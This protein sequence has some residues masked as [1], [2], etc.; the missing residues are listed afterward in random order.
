MYPIGLSSCGK[1]LCE[2][3]FAQYEAAGIA[4]MELSLGN[5][6]Y[7]TLPYADVEK[8]AAAHHITLWSLH[9]PFTG[10]PLDISSPNK[11]IQR[12]TIARHAELIKRGAEIGIQKFVLHPSTEPI[13][14]EAREEHI[15]TAQES[16]YNLADVANRCGAIIAVENLPRT[17]LGRSAAEMVRL[18]EIDPRLGICF[19]TNHLLGEEP[20]SFVHRLGAK[21]VTTHV[22]DYDMVDERHWLPGEGRVNWP[23]LIQAMAAIDYRGVWLYELNFKAPKSISRPRDLTCEDFASNAREIFARKKPSLITAAE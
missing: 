23:S 11:E 6:D 14:D 7:D 5:A 22:S 12:G 8:W 2:E 18:T 3:L 1:P 20:I 16:L 21:I 17:C 19:D 9:L 4:A 15:L 13:A 10:M